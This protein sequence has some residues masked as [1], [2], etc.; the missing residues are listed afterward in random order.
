[1]KELSLEKGQQTLVCV[2]S[3]LELSFNK[4]VRAA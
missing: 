2:L 1:M 4:L 3:S